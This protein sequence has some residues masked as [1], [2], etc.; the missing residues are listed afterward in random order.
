MWEVRAAGL[1]IMTSMRGD[2]KP[3]SIIEDCAV[4]LR[5]LADYTERLNRIFAK[6][7]TTGTF[8]AH[9]SVGCLHVRPVLNVKHDEDVGKLRAIAEEAFAIVRE[10]GGAHSGEHGDGIVRSEFHEEMFGPRIVEAFRDVKTRVRPGGVLNPGKIVDA[11]KMDDR[12]LFRYGPRYAPLPLKTELDWSEF[13]CVH[14]RRGDVQQQRR[15]PQERGRRDV[16]VVPRDRRRAPR[17]A[18]PRKRLAARAHGPARPGRSDVARIVRR[19]RPVRV[20]QGVQD[21]NARP[22]STW[23]G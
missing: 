15:V 9:A 5:H 20:V 8:Y 2:A 13:G 4:P 6:Y 3:I 21:A 16:P 18:R 12:T 14:R 7:G 1:N 19:A 22:A 11:P 17:D 10:Y 23:R